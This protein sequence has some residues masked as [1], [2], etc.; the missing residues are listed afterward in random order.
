MYR[1]VVVPTPSTS[2]SAPMPPAGL[3]GAT[4]PGLGEDAG[5]HPVARAVTSLLLGL[6]VGLASALLLPRRGRP[7]SAGSTTVDPSRTASTP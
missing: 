3:G 7:G 6:G 2:V 4:V 5:P 1:R